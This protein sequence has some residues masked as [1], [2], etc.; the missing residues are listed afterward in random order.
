MRLLWRVR[1]IFVVALLATAA[2]S[3]QVSAHSGLVSSYPGTNEVVTTVF[4][5]LVLNFDSEVNTDLIAL[6]LVWHGRTFSTVPSSHGWGDT[7]VFRT[8]QGLSNGDWVMRWTVIAIDGHVTSGTVPFAVKVP[9]GSA[10]QG[11]TQEHGGAPSGRVAPVTV[12][13]LAAGMVC[14]GTICWGLDVPPFRLRQ[15]FKRG[16]TRS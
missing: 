4:P 9:S 16:R 1:N 10:P 15:R 2:T 12:Q 6:H 11:S 7:A 8:R 3:S 5:E 14:L 13:G